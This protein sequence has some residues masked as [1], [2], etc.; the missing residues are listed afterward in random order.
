M[1]TFAVVLLI[2][3]LAIPATAEKNVMVETALHYFTTDESVTLKFNTVENATDYEVFLY[4]IN[5][6]EYNMKWIVTA[7]ETDPTIGTLTFKL[8]LSGF[9]KMMIRSRKQLNHTESSQVT[10]SINAKTTK[11]ELLEYMKDGC[12]VGN[13]WDTNLTLDELKALSHQEEYVCGEFNDSTDGSNSLVIDP[14]SG[15]SYNRGWTLFG[16]PAPPTGGGVSIQ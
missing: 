10:L 5:R 8:P 13:W 15:E 16:Y 12:T 3:L 6:K 9:Y 1:K 11:E 7:D 2:L 14:D 4:S